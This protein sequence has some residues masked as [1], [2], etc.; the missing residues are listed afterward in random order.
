MCLSVS[1]TNKSLWQKKAE[2]SG[3]VPIRGSVEA[4]QLFRDENG[5]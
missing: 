2:M 1:R 3:G 5:N 4:G